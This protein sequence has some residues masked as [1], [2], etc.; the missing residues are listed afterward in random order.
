MF[1]FNRRPSVDLSF[2]SYLGA[3]H[4]GQLARVLDLSVD[5]SEWPLLA[6]IVLETAAPVSIEVIDSTGRAM[7][8]ARV[9]H[10]A[11]TRSWGGAADS[12]HE[13]FLVQASVSDSEGRAELPALFGDQEIWAEQGIL[14]SRPWHGT[15]P[16]HVV[17]ALSESFT[18]GGMITYPNRHEWAAGYEGERR[19]LVSGEV[20]GFWRPLGAVR[21][22]AEGEW[23]PLR[24]PLENV[25]RVRLR[26]EGAP[27]TP[28][29]RT[30]EV[31][32][33][34]GHVRHDF[35]AVK[36][37]HL[38]FFVH[39]TAGV[40]IPLASA[41]VW[42]ESGLP[43]DGRYAEGA[44]REN[45]YA[46]VG[47]FPAGT[48]FYR[49]SATGFSS[50]DGTVIAPL[51][52]SIDITLE[53]AGRIAGRC[54]IDGKPVPNFDVIYWKQ[55]TPRT[56]RRQTFL[57]REDGTFGLDD[58]DS[59]DWFVHAACALHPGGEPVAVRVSSGELSEV[60]I[61]IPT[62]IRGGGRVVDA[63]TG[64][65][66]PDARIQMF[67]SGGVERTFPWG[68]PVT[69]GSDG[70]FFVE[71]LVQGT[72]FL[73]VEADGYAP[74]EVST[75]VTRRPFVELG[76]LAL[77][78]PQTLRVALLGLQALRGVSPTELIAYSTLGHILPETPFDADGTVCFHEVSPGELGLM[79]GY[80]DSSWV[81]LN[82]QL[83]PGKD[84]AFTFDLGGYRKLDL[85]VLDVEGEQIDFEAMV[86]VLAQEETGIFIE[87]LGLPRADGHFLF[88]GIR[89]D[90]I[91]VLV[92][93]DDAT[94][95]ASRDFSF[96]GESTLTA[97][98]R[99]E[100]DPI[101]V[102]VV[103]AEG[104]PL[105]GAWVRF[106]SPSGEFRGKEDTD[107]DGW[108]SILGVPEGPALVDVSH[109]IAGQRQGIPVD[110]SLREHEIVLDARGSLE[111]RLVD[112]EL[113]LASVAARIVTAG[114]VTLSEAMQ[115]DAQ[116]IVRFQPLG[117]GTYRI[118]F[119]RADCWPATI[120][121]ALATGE[122]ARIDVQMR[123]VADLELTLFD[124]DGIPVS[125]AEIGLTSIEFESTVE[126]W[127]GAETV[128][129]PK[130]LRTDSLGVLRVEGLP[131]GTYAWSVPVGEELARGT[132]ELLPGEL[133]R[134]PIR[135]G[136]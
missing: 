42:W 32:L 49:V 95:I 17:L 104:A 4:S 46:W 66:L 44:A 132:F 40:P 65:S 62:G 107:A 96:A 98:I 78:R 6:E 134:V 43:T 3:M 75:N 136:P 71:G 38:W 58:V 120:E 111:L 82:L 118:A 41:M 105:V 97:E 81:R 56:P 16:S 135:L 86:L 14:V 25:S 5:Q 112:G 115:T 70:G 74:L 27:I 73:T 37:E 72:N 109:G 64:S 47:T 76:D 30:L 54:T 24:I 68:L 124:R 52:N 90:E 28:I 20:G 50:E 93:R 113:P 12:L 89:A 77:H 130:G 92:Y 126:A 108:A 9:H 39:D 84:W 117:E 15:T 18:V 133:N 127:L 21:D 67:S 11:R 61:E 114:G 34:G 60:E 59:G 91:Q 100:G 101:R 83:D 51:S 129:A 80:P 110:A 85:Q 7:S 102:R 13:R 53:E 19:I 55:G 123:Q 119:Q 1:E 2:G 122:Q 106:W 36:Q 121:R 35:V 94:L 125:G 45:G 10:V 33:Q 103:D 79:I 26:L 87:R 128:R 88:E 22:V 116:G 8:G 29:E 48:V 57:D 23:G 63:K 69:T 131:R 31:P 99:L